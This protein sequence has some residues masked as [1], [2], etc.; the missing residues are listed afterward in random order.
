MTKGASSTSAIVTGSKGRLGRAFTV[1]L[2]RDGFQ[3]ETVD[4]GEPRRGPAAGDKPYLFDCA[5]RHDEP[6]QHVERVT[7]HLAQWRRYAAIFVPSSMWIDHDHAYGRAKRQ[8]EHLAAHYTLLGARVVTD[9]IGYFPGDGVEPDR[10][11][12]M[13]DHRVTGDALYARVMHRMR[14]TG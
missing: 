5:Y 12:P 14:A 6:D 7:A 13:Y 8:V 3:V 10:N 2:R 11:D 4:D 1:R 9:R